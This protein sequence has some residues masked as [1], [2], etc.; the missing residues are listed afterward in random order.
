MIVILSEA[1]DLWLTNGSQIV[2]E[3]LRFAQNDSVVFWIG[4]NPSLCLRK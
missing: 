3:I 4:I 2:T 1:K